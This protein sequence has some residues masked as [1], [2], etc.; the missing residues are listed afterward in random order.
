M[1]GGCK[2][3]PCSNLHRKPLKNRKNYTKLRGG[4]VG[5]VSQLGEGE[6]V[7]TPLLPRGGVNISL[8]GCGLVL[9]TFMPMSSYRTG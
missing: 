7:F 5:V 4:G 2:H 6:R 8:R 3:A 9:P 1:S